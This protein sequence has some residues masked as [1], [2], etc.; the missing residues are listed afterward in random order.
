MNGSSADTVCESA[1]PRAG[2]RALLDFLPKGVSLPEDVWRKRHAWFV[3][4]LWLHAL[5]LGGFAAYMG[6]SLGE[7]LAVAGILAAL[8]FLGG[9]DLGSRRFRAT[10]VSFGYAMASGLLVHLSGGY[11]EMHFHYFV[12]VTF[13]VLYQDWVP[14]LISVGFVGLQHGLMGVLMPHSVY[15]HPDAV[16]H[17]WK[18]ASIHALFLGVASV[19]SVVAWRTIEQTVEQLRQALAARKQEAEATRRLNEELEAINKELEA[20]SYSVSHDLRAPLRHIDGFADLLKRHA[21]SGVDEK[22]RRYLTTISESAKQMGHLIDDL[23]AFSRIG[24]TELSKTAVDLDTMVAE[25]LESLRQDTDGR[26]IVWTVAPLPS[27]FGDPSLLRQVWI[28]LIGNAVKYTL[29]RDEARIE[30]GSRNGTPGEVV[31]FVRDNGVG[32]DM[33]YVDKLFGVFQRLHSASEFEGTGIGLANVQRIVRRHGGRVWGE[34]Q[35]DLGATFYVSL[36]TS[37]GAAS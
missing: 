12:M 27:V 2:A 1:P 8:A 25:V 17:P 18:W 34:A 16:A 4:F 26:R 15:N 9:M 10:V 32:F 7:C 19:G 22:G 3:R 13:L 24:R 20:F 37:G 11:I 23:L 6:R 28:N 29:P 31:V 35:V 30:I 14:F 5:A 21:T 36:P 33:K